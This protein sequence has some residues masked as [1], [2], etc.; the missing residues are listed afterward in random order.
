MKDNL[1]ISEKF[2]SIQ[3][4]GQTMGV[5]SIFVRL[6]GC[7]I[8]CQSDSWTCDSI[9]VWKKG[10][11][12]PFEEVLTEEEVDKLKSGAHLIFTG[13]EPLLHQKAIIEYLKWLYKN[14]N[15]YPII[16]VETNGTIMPDKELTLMVKYWNCSPKLPNS[17]ESF[18]RR[19]KP[20]VIIRL[21]QLSGTIFK[22][23]INGIDDYDDMLAEYGKYLSMN[24][25]C[26]MPAGDSQEKLKE[27]RQ[28]VAQIC[29]KKC[30]KYSERLHIVIWN[31]KT[32]V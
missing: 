10:T 12:T 3:G 31:Q 32:G 16:E 8:L 18:A 28:I 22:F 9:K 2:Y 29:I 20:E 30:L 27:V 7:N 26:L 19:V 17:G 1:V 13:G 21:N 11:K 6:A 23:V 24:K 14:H 25:V 5:P 15:F 4:E